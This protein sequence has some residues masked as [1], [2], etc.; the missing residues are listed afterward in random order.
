MRLGLA[1]LLCL[2]LAGCD[3]MFGIRVRRGDLPE[4]PPPGWEQ[5]GMKPG[6]TLARMSPA[7]VDALCRQ[8]AT[9]GTAQH[10]NPY[11]VESCVIPSL[12]EVVMP[13]EGTWDKARDEATQAHEF[14]H[15]WGLTH[16]GARSVD[17]VQFNGVRP[18]PMTPDVAARMISAAKMQAAAQ[19]ENALRVRPAPN[20]LKE[21]R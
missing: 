10:W 3:R 19:A 20:A 16:P 7:D 17:W 2:V 4:P 12:H 18:A 14:V 21:A 5:L 6:Y 15:S 8:Y 9:Q 1:L 13:T 11:R